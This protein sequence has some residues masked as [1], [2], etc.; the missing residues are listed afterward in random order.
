MRRS[1][2]RFLDASSELPPHLSFI[3]NLSPS[4]MTLG[5]GNMRALSD[6]LGHPER[7]FRS[8]LVA[9]TNGKGS[10]T[11]HLSAILVANGLH[12]GTYT[13]PH[14]Y[15]VTERVCVGGEPV[16]IEEMEAAAARITPLHERIGY[17]Y[18][19]ALTAVAFLIFAARGVEYAV[20]EVGLGGRFDATNVV[21]PDVSI[22]TGISLDHRR[23]LGDTEEE[24]L[25]EK[26]GIAR[27]GV[28]L[29]CGPL[30]E[31]LQA[32]V[33]A[34]ARDDEI[35]LHWADDEGTARLE[36]L[37]FEGMRASVATCV[38]DYTTI[39]IPFLGVHQLRNTLL[40]L[41]AAELVIGN[42][43][44]LEAAARGAVLRGRFDVIEKGNKRVVLDVAH[45]DE[46]LTSVS[47]TIERLGSR[48]RSALVLGVLARKELRKFGDILPRFFGRVY[49]IDPLPGETFTPQALLDR[50]CISNL[51]DRRLDVILERPFQRGRDVDG[52]IENLLDPSRPFDVILV[53]GSHRTVEI[54]GRRPTLGAAT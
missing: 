53:A 19:E 28:P 9:G 22:L 35:P 17:S 26:L 10:V 13:S 37:T 2:P 33:E 30:A 4:V 46:A 11:A 45:N 42:V 41:R 49:L 21:D 52:F 29:V 16:T 25:R 27:S 20:L 36:E 18:F 44:H 1:L 12:V 15:R 51:K 50:L 31:E 24:I 23:L 54:F 34:R 39:R 14:V 43:G 3:L 38:R 6:A 32:I 47:E 48:D 8:V 5:L 7:E 40:A